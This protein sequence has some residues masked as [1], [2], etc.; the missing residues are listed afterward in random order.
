M[1]HNESSVK[2]KD[3]STK[4]LHKEGGK[5]KEHLKTLGKKERNSPRKNK[6]QKLIKLRAEINKI[7]TTTTKQYEESMRQSV[8]LENQKYR[9]TFIQT[10]QKAERISKLAKSEMKREP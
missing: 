5:L 3:H 6:Q 9:K 4:C 8:G 2:R 7:E 10:N 1:R